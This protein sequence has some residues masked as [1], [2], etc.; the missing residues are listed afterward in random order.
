MYGR[1]RTRKRNGRLV[2]S[3]VDA[4]TL[5]SQKVADSKAKGKKRGSTS[6]LLD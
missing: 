4:D 5:A 1:F 3:A 6:G 2:K